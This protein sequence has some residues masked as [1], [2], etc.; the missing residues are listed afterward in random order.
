MLQR[1]QPPLGQS[2][3]RAGP[4]GTRHNEPRARHV[5]RPESFHANGRC[6]PSPFVHILR[7]RQSPKPS[8]KIV[9][10]GSNFVPSPPLVPTSVQ[11]RKPGTWLRGSI[12]RPVLTITTCGSIR[13]APASHSIST[14]PDSQHHLDTFC[15]KTEYNLFGNQTT[16]LL[17]IVELGK[18]IRGGGGVVP[19]W[20]RSG[21]RG[22]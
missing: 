11:R 5:F 19:L 6:Q 10:V 9:V 22:D 20:K 14:R 21:L 15:F 8:S 1:V 17:K 7:P 3:D 18:E 13:T 16:I 2:N 4:A 12:R